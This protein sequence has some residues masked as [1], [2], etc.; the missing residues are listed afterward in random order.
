MMSSLFS[1][2]VKS[3]SNFDKGLKK[4]PVKS[5]VN[6]KE[7]IIPKGINTIY[8]IAIGIV[9]LYNILIISIYKNLF[10]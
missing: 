5:S 6:T 9:K 2:N 1:I 7:I 4:Y 10:K 8:N 3:S